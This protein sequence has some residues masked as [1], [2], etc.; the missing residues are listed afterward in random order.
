[1]KSDTGRQLLFRIALL[2]CILA[3]AG[4][5]VHGLKATVAQET[6]PK[7]LQSELPELSRGDL[8]AIRAVTIQYYEDKKP[9]YWE[10]FVTELRRGGIFLKDEHPDIGP[11]IGLWKLEMLDG[12]L[13]LVRRQAPP[14]VNFFGVGLTRKD[15]KWIAVK[16]FVGEELYKK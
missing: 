15:G 14:K 10:A 12:E 1:L 2:S 7:A 5:A 6:M 9:E 4:A 13:A 3:F 11:A 16:D 8:E